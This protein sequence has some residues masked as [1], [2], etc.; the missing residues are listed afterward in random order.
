MTEPPTRE[1]PTRE[2]PT[3]EP[4]TRLPDGTIKQV[5]P[6]N[7]TKVWTLPGRSSRPL[8]HVVPVPLA[9]DPDD[10]D[11]ICAFCPARKLETTPE[12]A[13]LVRSGDGWRE[14]RGVLA[15]EVDD[16]TAEFRLIPNLFEI[17]TYD[18]WH[19]T[20][21][22]VPTP[23]SRAHREAYLATAAGR[24]HIARLATIRMRGRGAVGVDPEP[25]SEADLHREAVGLFAGNHQV[26]VARR[27]FVEDATLDTQLAGS[28]TLTPDEHDAYTGLAIRAM[29]DLYHDNPAARY[30][31]VF[32]N[33]LRP[34][35]ASFDHLHKQVVAI[36]ELGVQIERESARLH[37]E[38][39]LYER[40]G[41][42]YAAEQGL[43]IART[44]TAVAFV[45]IGHRFPSLEAHSLVVDRC[46]WELTD[47]EVRDF[48][49]VL[50]VCHAAT[51]VGVPSN[52]EWHHKPPSLDLPMPLRAV[53]KWRVSTL[54]GFEG[55]TKIYVN[56]LDPWAV[57]DH[58]R[59][60]LRGLT[61]RRQVSSRITIA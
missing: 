39:D 41:P 54:A 59:G 30:V 13:R 23:E 61:E 9:V 21:G 3:R 49:D 5:N 51:G 48:S 6:F 25:L 44:P 4:L 27:H 15:E 29:R 60:R 8:E 45:G 11:R 26:I 17:L 33:W 1:R 40:W 28:G 20:H 52:E 58:A 32:Q 57:R 24:S 34:G 19:L 38:P 47:D 37:T 46:P 50:H 35:G 2:R 43:V 7:D 12:V 31:S 22:Y 36:D 14:L 18:Y 10:A 55:G 56:T 16:T 53:L 42:T